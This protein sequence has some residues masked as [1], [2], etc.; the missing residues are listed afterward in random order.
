MKALSIPGYSDLFKNQDSNYDELLKQTSSDT[1]VMLLISLNLE[2]NTK[3]TFEENQKRLLN[4]VAAR[5]T[6]EQLILLKNALNNYKSKSRNYTTPNYNGV[7]F[8]RRYLLSM[9]LKEFKRDNKDVVE[10]DSPI[11]EY[12]FFLSYLLMVE[13]VNKSDYE[14]MDAAKRYNLKLMPALPLLWA[15]NIR[16]YEFNN[17]PNASFELFKILSF[18]KYSYDNYRT[19]LK[20]LIN[21]YGFASISQF[22]S[23]FNQIIKATMTYQP[24]EVLKKLY[25]ITPID[26]DNLSHLDSLC[27]NILGN[28]DFK[29][30]DL[31]RFPLYKTQKRGYMVI[32]E[33]IYMKKVYR[34]PLFELYKKITLQTE[35]TFE[36]YKTDISKS[37]SEDILFK[38]I[39][40]QMT[41]GEN[42]IGHYDGNSK[43]GEP[44]LY[45]RFGNEIVLIEFK[46]YCFPESV[47]KSKNFGTFRKYIDERFLTSDANK[48]KGV[49]QL[50]NY[51]DN[52]LNKKYIFDSELN[53][54]LDNGDHIKIYPIIC[55]TDFMF[56]MPGLNEYLNCLFSRELKAKKNVYSAVH[57]VTLIKLEVLFDLS[58]REKKLADL[59]SLLSRYYQYVDVMRRKYTSTSSIDDF[60]SSTTSFDEFYQTKFRSG[61]IDNGDLTSS[62]TTKTMRD[63]LGISQEEL[64]II[65]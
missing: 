37:C 55:H 4:A 1:V 51:I 14:L 35:I 30:D 50:A 52:L 7:I 25:F 20:E 49:S 62:H 34:G 12:K 36:D 9:L 6:S 42:S 15:S 58:L 60:V 39:V 29:I 16:K 38:G 18:C 27:I 32:D 53:S 48:K 19:Y 2:L 10:E 23:S 64:D 46:D 63:I 5:F 45:F 54:K 59:L 40:N 31:R 3:E 43:N 28:E 33:N 57:R 26:T 11:H 17:W 41:R 47:L 61:M 56:S 44:D 8:G 13:E 65:L 24:N 21:K 22:V